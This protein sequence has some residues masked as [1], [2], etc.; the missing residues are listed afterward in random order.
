[1]IIKQTH[2]AVKIFVVLSGNGT[3]PRTNCTHRA[4]NSMLTSALNCCTLSPLSRMK[5]PKVL[6][7]I[8]FLQFFEQTT[9]PPTKLHVSEARNADGESVVCFLKKLLK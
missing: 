1:M 3:V 8:C 5:P 9:A 4:G 7:D 2:I 6:R